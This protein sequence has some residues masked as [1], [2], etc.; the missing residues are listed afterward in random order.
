MAV[1]F[2]FVLIVLA[3]VAPA[4]PANSFT[5]KD[6]Q[7]AFGRLDTDADGKVTRT[8]YND[9]KISAIYRNIP[10][11][12]PSEGGDVAF[13]QVK[14]SR[15]FFDASDSDHNGRLSPIEVTRSLQFEAIATEGKD[16]F[17]RDELGRFMKGIG[18]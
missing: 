16:Y 18:R 13:E 17:T 9:K 2:L 1:R 3:L 5:E 15:E 7:Q 12:D 4:S 8:E 11:D 10:I 14:L 6:V